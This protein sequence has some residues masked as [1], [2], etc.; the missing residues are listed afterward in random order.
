MRLKRSSSRFAPVADR[1][2][3]FCLIISASEM[4]NSAVL[5]A[6]AIDISS[7]SSEGLIMSLPISRL[8][9]ITTKA[10]AGLSDL[11]NL[12]SIDLTV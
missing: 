6:P 11:S 7:L 5:M 1:M 12:P 4:P 3:F 2:D 9:S 8:G 10:V